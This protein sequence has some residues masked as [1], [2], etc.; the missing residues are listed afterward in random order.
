MET[1]GLF[2]TYHPAICMIFFIAAVAFSFSSTHPVYVAI[3]AF[4]AIVYLVYL[5]G[6]RGAARS[7][8]FAIPFILFIAL[9]NFLFSSSGA[10]AL[11]HL[12]SIS[13]DVPTPFGTYP[14]KWSLKVTVEGLCYGLAMGGMLTSVILW[15]GCYNEVMT[16]DKFTYLF[17]K[18]L[19]TLALVVSMVSRWVPHMVVRGRRIYD[20]QEALI[21]GYDPSKKALVGR[22]IRMATVLAGLGMEDSIQTSDS[23]RARGFGT[24][25]RTTYARYPW[26]AREYA[27][28]VLLV[29]LIAVN[30]V[31]LYLGT[32]DF[33]Y[34]PRVSAVQP[35]WGYITY[36][37]LLSVPFLT[38]LEG[39]Y[40]ALR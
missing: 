21:G 38:E 12:F 8:L 24:A 23:M 3:S 36:L 37:L 32:K 7:L 40:H 2:P 13:I 11:A 9:L 39:A 28:L 1:K 18:F 19:P 22:G 14:F 26:H 33:T 16:D 4:M 29:L 34:Y 20:S 31:G 30:I 17:G 27:V 15:F 25:K 5:K 35:W 6:V 10:T